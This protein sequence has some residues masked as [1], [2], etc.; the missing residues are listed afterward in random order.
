MISFALLPALLEQVVAF[1]HGFE[2]VKVFLVLLV[3]QLLLDDRE[4]ALVY[5]KQATL[6]LCEAVL[7]ACALV[8]LLEQQLLTYGPANID[9][10]EDASRLDRYRLH[11]V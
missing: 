11:V 9:S 7:L 1:E 8:D 5:A 2:D 10:A 6:G 3:Q 4:L